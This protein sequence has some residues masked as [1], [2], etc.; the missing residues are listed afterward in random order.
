MKVKSIV[1]AV[2]LLFAADAAR[3]ELAIGSGGKGFTYDSM[4]NSIVGVCSSDTLKLRNVNSSGSD[5]NLANLIKGS[6]HLAI[7]QADALQFEAM[8]DPRAGENNIKVLMVLHPEEVHVIARSDLKVGGMLGF[9][10]SAA[11]G[12][13]Q[14]RGLKIGAWGGSYT[15]ARAF[16]AQTNLGYEAIKFD[17]PDEATAALK[18][19]DVQAIIRVAGQE[20]AYTA[21]LVKTRQF[22]LLNVTP[23]LASAASFYVPARLNYGGTAV[24]S[25]AAQALLV[26][27][28]F[29]SAQKK[30]EVSELKDCIIKNMDEFREGG[31][32]HAKWKEVDLNATS[33]RGFYETNRLA[34]PQEPAKASASATAKKK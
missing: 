12:I 27:S 14:L 10:G 23:S 4:V 17:K 25:L 13:E 19:K 24:P 32:H 8:Q 5:E 28:N 30:Q 34:S 18:A 16:N 15:T 29:R 31:G 26:T 20:D 3:A 33:A 11:Q 2:A 7:V 21:A 1:A 9:G 22:Q 6:V